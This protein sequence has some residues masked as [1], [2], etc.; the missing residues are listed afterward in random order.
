MQAKTA[1][2][3]QIVFSNFIEHGPPEPQHQS[4]V[5]SPASKWEGTIRLCKPSVLEPV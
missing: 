3:Q 1:E 4:I 2:M 5:K